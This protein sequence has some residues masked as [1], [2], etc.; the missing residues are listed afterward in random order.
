MLAARGWVGA[1]NV[2]SAAK[3]PNRSVGAEKV[4]PSLVV[5]WTIAPAGAPLPWTWMGPTARTSP[6]AAG[7]RI[8]AGAVRCVSGPRH[9]PGPS[10]LEAIEDPARRT[11]PDGTPS[12]PVWLRPPKGPE[13]NHPAATTAQTTRL[14]ASSATRCDDP[15]SRTGWSCTEDPFDGQHATGGRGRPQTAES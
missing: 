6:P 4:S 12:V 15:A 14:T 2:T 10:V 11:A 1:R 13:P 5:S 7:V 3:S 9:G 8:V